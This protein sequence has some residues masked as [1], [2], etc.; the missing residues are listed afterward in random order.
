[1][2]WLCVE[3]STRLGLDLEILGSGHPLQSWPIAPQTCR[4]LGF[5]VFCGGEWKSLEQT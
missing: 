3:Q 2:P 1:M 5:G 4:I